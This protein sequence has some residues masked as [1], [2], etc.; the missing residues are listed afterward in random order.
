[1]S[2]PGNVVGDL[3]S[4]ASKTSQETQCGMRSARIRRR[5]GGLTMRRATLMWVLLVGCG[6]SSGTPLNDGGGGPDSPN[7]LDSGN[8]NDGAAQDVQPA[9]CDGG[10]VSCNGMCVDTQ[11]DM[12]NCGGC[13][14]R[15]QHHVHGWRLLAHRSELRRRRPNRRRQRVPH[16]RRD[17]RLLGHGASPTG[18]SGRYPSAA[19]RRAGHRRRPAARTAWRPTGRTSSS[20]TRARRVTCTGSIQSDPVGRHDATPDRDRPVRSRSPSPSTPRTSTGPT[21]ATARCGRATR[22]R[23]TRAARGRQ[24]RHTR[25][26]LPSTRPTSTSRIS[27]APASSTASPIAGGTVTG[28]MTTTGV[29]GAGQIAID[30]DQRLLRLARH[31]DLRDPVDRPDARRGG[32]RAARP[33]PSV[34]Q[35]HRDRRH[36][37]SGSPRPR[38]SSPTWRAPARSTASRSPARSDTILASKQNGPNCISVDTTSV[39]WIDTGGG[40][41]AKTGK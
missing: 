14:D 33:E 31:D 41:I 20:P 24:R 3:R 27:T 40:M 36:A 1:M 17:Q 5:L 26:Y 4:R 23:P 16:D 28:A 34:H 11:T 10:E 38:T 15:V 6:G 9:S 13:G 25:N 8:P 39:Y 29:P 22:P 35:R 18:A 2:S 37:T 7:N 32:A 19:A 21:R 12:N 30:D